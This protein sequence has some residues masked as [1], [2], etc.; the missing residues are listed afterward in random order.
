MQKQASARYQQRSFKDLPRFSE[1]EPAVRKSTVPDGHTR[2]VRAFAAFRTARKCQA[3]THE[4]K[5]RF[6]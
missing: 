1:I 5:G 3:P 6:Y 2:F 4:R